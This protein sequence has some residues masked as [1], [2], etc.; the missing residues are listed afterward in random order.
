MKTRKLI[1]EDG[2]EYIGTG[3]GSPEEKK[4]E[5]VFNT[6]M[7]GYQEIISDLSYTDQAVVMTYPLIGN[8]GTMEA[9]N[10]SDKPGIR[11]L[12]VREYCDRPSNFRCEKTLEQMMIANGIAG[13]QGVDTRQ[14]ARHIRNYGSCKAMITDEMAD[15]AK[16]VAE[17]KAWNPPTD[18]V[19]R[20]SCDQPFVLNPDGTETLLRGKSIPQTAHNAIA[21]ID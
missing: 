11:G 16:A 13:I 1:L 17:L 14:I 5:L 2:S 20:A 12:I 19:K 18:Q 4:I 6:S 15:T 21:V 8:Y 3:F 9:D 7:A 10:E